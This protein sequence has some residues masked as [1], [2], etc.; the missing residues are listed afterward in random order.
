MPASTRP[1]PL[2]NND[3]AIH[4]TLRVACGQCHVAV[5]SE[6]PAVD[7]LKQLNSGGWRHQLVNGKMVQ[8]CPVCA[9]DGTHHGR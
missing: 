2:T 6:Q 3:I 4:L 1:Q 7:F 8:K 9:A 5:S